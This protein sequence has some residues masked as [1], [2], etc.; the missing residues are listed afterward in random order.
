MKKLTAL[1]LLSIAVVS[2][3]KETKTVTKTDPKTGKT[4][5]VEV[6]VTDSTKSA[7]AAT[8]AVPAIKDSLG[9]YKQSFKLAK[10][11][12]YPLTTYQRDV[13][14]I[15][16]P[17]GQ[18][19]SGTS[20]STDEMTFTVDDFD[21][22]VYDI[23]INLVGKRNSQTANGKTVTVD[24]KQAAPA[25]NNLKMMWNVN[26]ALTGNKLKMKMQED[27]K[28]LSI[29]GFD[30]IYAKIGNSAG[31]LIKDANQKNAFLKSFKQSFSEAT[32]KEQFSKNLMVLPVKGA[33]LGEKWTESSNAT[34]DGKVKIVTTY[35]LKNVGNGVAQIAVSGGIPYKSEKRN[36][37]GMSHSMSS[38][39]VQSGTITLDQN[40]GWIKNQNI[41]VKTT[42]TES[43]SD[44]KQ[45]QSMKSVSNS[46][47]MVNPNNK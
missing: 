24:T 1:A 46:T 28:V 3:K 10:G 6:P 32:M 21:K 39:L 43:I 44:G 14:T 35:T 47:V 5:T 13:Q 34:P 12:T 29:T 22:G 30:A 17:N 9:V 20:E 45:T 36:Q 40:T 41:G 18:T 16:A 4:I 42:Q 15:S 26:K 38:E 23:T 37:Q 7:T 11:Q 25:D 31:S 2:C 8:V 27:G 33:K 19:Q